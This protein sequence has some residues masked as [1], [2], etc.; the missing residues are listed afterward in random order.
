MWESSNVQD[1]R[2]DK[3]LNGDCFQVLINIPTREGK[4]YV[5]FEERYVCCPLLYPLVPILLTNLVVKGV[6]VT[7]FP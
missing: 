4:A 6:M 2:Y 1:I 5:L 7:A 3:T